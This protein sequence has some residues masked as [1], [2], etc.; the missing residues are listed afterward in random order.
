MRRLESL[1]SFQRWAAQTTERI[2]REVTEEAERVRREV[3]ERVRREAE[4]RAETKGVIRSLLEYFTA[5]GDVPTLHALETM[6][7]CT[8][9]TTAQ[10]WLKRA[11]AGETPAQIFPDDLGNPTKYGARPQPG[12]SY[13]SLPVLHGCRSSA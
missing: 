6:N 5:K 7:A 2:R 10:Y 12:G 4:Q 1:P 3:E 13:A 11:Y 8:T 9:L